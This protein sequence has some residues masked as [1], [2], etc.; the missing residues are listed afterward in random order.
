MWWNTVTHERG[1]EEETAEWSG[2][3][4]PFTLPRNTVYPAL[5]PLMRT[6]RLPA[7]DWTD[8]PHLF[9]WTRPFRL[10]TK[11]GFCACAV[12]FQMQST[13]TYHTTQHLSLKTWWLQYVPPTVILENLEFRWRLL[14]VFHIV[15]IKQPLPPYICLLGWSLQWKRAAFTCR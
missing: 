8:A 6:P 10:K 14:L 15:V 9:K 5:V 12:T 11:C 13:C 7:V 4:V 2:W 1:S 3:P